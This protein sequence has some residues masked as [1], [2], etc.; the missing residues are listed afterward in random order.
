MKITIE[1]IKDWDLVYKVA[2][3]TQGKRPLQ[4]YP[5]EKWKQKTVVAQHSPLRQLEFLITVE[6]VPNFVHNHLARHVHLQP[7]IQTMREDITGIAND[8]I[9]RN[10]HNSGTYIINAQEFIHV[11]HDRLCTKASAETRAVWECVVEEMFKI[12]PLLASMAVPHCVFCGY[13]KEYKSCGMSQDAH[14]RHD[15]LWFINGRD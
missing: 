12:E 11:S 15:Y 13:C 8:D 3:F 7:Y 9:T 1:K 4:Q 2:L 10:T 6:N 14:K 5:T